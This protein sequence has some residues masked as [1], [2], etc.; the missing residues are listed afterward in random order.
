MENLETQRVPLE[1]ASQSL[2]S[3]SSKRHPPWMGD[4]GFSDDRDVIGCR[5]SP[6]TK[7]WGV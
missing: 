2:H 1:L 7:T 5:H 3:S 6:T 4:T